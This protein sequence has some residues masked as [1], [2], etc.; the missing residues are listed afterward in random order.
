[1]TYDF[2]VTPPGDFA[3]DHPM[4]VKIEVRDAL[5]LLMIASFTGTRQPLTDAAIVRTWLRHPL[6]AL[7]VLA[8]IHWEA[9]KLWLKGVGLQRRPAPPVHQVSVE[10][11]SVPEGASGVPAESTRI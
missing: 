4:A 11:T 5:G 1:M 7:K 10:L 6:P 3:D 2:S 9:L 8:A